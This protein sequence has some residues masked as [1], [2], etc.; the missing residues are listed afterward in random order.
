MAGDFPGAS[1]ADIYTFA[2]GLAAAPIR[3]YGISFSDDGSGGAFRD[4]LSAAGT[5]FTIVKDFRLENL[6]F[7]V[8]T[9]GA[10]QGATLEKNRGPDSGTILDAKLLDVKDNRW[11]H[12]LTTRIRTILL[13]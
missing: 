1:Q 8:V 7:R 5:F 12:A 11:I 13:V 6:T 2:A 4:A 9:P 3:G 10:A